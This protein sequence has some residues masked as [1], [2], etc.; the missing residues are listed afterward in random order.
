MSWSTFD[1]KQHCL[2]GLIIYWH[3]DQYFVC[4]IFRHISWLTYFGWSAPTAGYDQSM[5]E[6]FDVMRAA[7]NVTYILRCHTIAA[8]RSSLE[9][10][11]LPANQIIICI[12]KYQLAH[13]DTNATPV[14]YICV[15][16]SEFFFFMKKCSDIFLSPIVNTCHMNHLYSQRLLSCDMKSLYSLMII[17]VLEGLLIDWFIALSTFTKQNEWLG[18]I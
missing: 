1:D 11:C 5:T 13:S 2:Y 4:N 6:Y 10:Y 3:E 14:R 16:N 9:A 8:L 12:T 17:S 18:W 15:A 7:L